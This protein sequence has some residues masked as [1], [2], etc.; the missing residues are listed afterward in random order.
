MKEVKIET[1]T[2]NNVL[3]YIKEWKEYEEAERQ[4]H[5]VS[6]YPG[7]LSKKFES[8]F[9]SHKYW[10]EFIAS[11]FTTLHSSGM[12]Y[13][14]VCRIGDIKISI[15]ALDEKRGCLF[16]SDPHYHEK[17]D[18]A[19]NSALRLKE[20]MPRSSWFSENFDLDELQRLDEVGKQFRPTAA[21]SEIEDLIQEIEFKKKRIEDLN[22]EIETLKTL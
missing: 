3:D 18:L 16:L 10:R 20:E 15:V 22:K 14:E 12:N 6:T 9:K 2:S 7:Y 1:I 17:F 8:W 5:C 13:K 4:S 21:E 19:L 11:K